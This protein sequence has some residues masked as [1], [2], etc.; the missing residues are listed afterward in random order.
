[1][2]WYQRVVARAESEQHG[3]LGN[4]PGNVRELRP[5]RR[6]DHFA[7]PGD[8]YDV[9]VLD[10]DVEGAVMQQPVVGAAQQHEVVQ[11]RL[12]AVDPVPDV[13]RLDVA[14]VRTAGEAS[15]VVVAQLQSPHQPRRDERPPG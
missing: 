8:E 10:G 6:F 15:A 4:T 13:V 5:Q 14:Q 11:P 3:F 1:M 9:T 2:L 12:A 7:V